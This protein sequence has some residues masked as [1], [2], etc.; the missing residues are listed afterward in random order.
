VHDAA[1]ST[2]ESE[3][4]AIAEAFISV[5]T[6][7][8]IH[9][10]LAES[11]EKG[12]LDQYIEAECIIKLALPITILEDNKA[13]I[14]WASKEM[15]TSR[16]R[17]VEKS[18]YWVSQYTASKLIKLEYIKSEDQ[19]ADLGTKPLSVTVFNYIPYV[20]IKQSRYP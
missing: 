17:H 15:N 11:V 6:A 12:V 13:A 3:I 2:C 1:L 4:R 9:K 14:Q 7:L 20:T 10:L 5:K 19:L 18:F 8:Y 16:M